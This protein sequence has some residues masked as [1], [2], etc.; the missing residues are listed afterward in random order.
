MIKIFF[1]DDNNWYIKKCTKWYEM[2]NKNK[3]EEWS[4]VNSVLYNFTYDDTTKNDSFSL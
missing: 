2:K 1:N 3:V 4:Q